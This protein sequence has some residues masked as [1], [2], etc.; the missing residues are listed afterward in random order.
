[1]KKKKLNLLQ[2]YNLVNFLSLSLS[3]LLFSFFNYLKLGNYYFLKGQE[4]KLNNKIN[5]SK[6]YF[7]LSYKYILKS[8][9]EIT[10]P[11]VLFFYSFF[12]SYHYHSYS[13]SCE[14]D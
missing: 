7:E 8:I 3:S 14:L 9:E 13:Y 4:L 2:I 1:M 6:Y 10:D 12:F 11:M 5:E